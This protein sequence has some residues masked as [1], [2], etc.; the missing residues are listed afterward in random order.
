MR[1]K[2]LSS[3]GILAVLMVSIGACAPRFGLG[4]EAAQ[5]VPPVPQVETVLIAEV[6]HDGDP[7]RTD[8]QGREMPHFVPA[9]LL[10][11]GETV[12]YTVRIRNPSTAFI[13]DVT[14]VQK[15]PANTSYIAGSAAG[16][17]AR[18]TYSIDGGQTFASAA[19]LRVDVAGTRRA[20]APQQYT[21]IRWQLR[22]PLAPGT[23]AL[24]RFR[25]VFH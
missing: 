24:A 23:V 21:H 10:S 14:V 5:R 16:P 25:A 15:I 8:P 19:R 6:R 9:T 17:G 2:S 22:N 20:A 3:N 12:Y 13:P 1:D 18:I 4:E 11:Q 7:H